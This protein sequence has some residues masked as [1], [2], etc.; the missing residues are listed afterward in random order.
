MMNKCCTRLLFC[1]FY[2]PATVFAVH[3]WS[4]HSYPDEDGFQR[5]MLPMFLRIA[6][7][8]FGE[9]SLAVSRCPDTGL[10]VKVWAVE[11]ETIISPYTGRAY[12]QGPTGYF[13]PRAR[14]EKGEIIAFGGD[15][16]KKD[17]PP[18]AAALL[19]DPENIEARAFLSIP[20]NLRQQYHFACSNWARAWP[21]LSGIMGRRW[22][23]QFFYRVG[24]YAE[25]RRPSDGG[26]EHL[27]LAK[28]H[29]LVGEPGHLLGGN[30]KDGGTENHKTMWRTSALLYSQLFPDTAKISGYTVHEAEILVKKMI[31]DYLKRL[32]ETG[33]GEYDS[34]V[35]YPYT[36]KS[37]LNLYDFSPDPETR[38]LAQCALDYYFATYGLKV[39]DGAIAGAQKRGYLTSDAASMME[40]MQWGFFND[41]SRDM[42][43]VITTL[44]QA[45]TNYRPNRVIYDITR[46]NIALP[47]EA[48]MGRPFYHMD[49]AHAF[50]E[51]FY[52]SMS[53]AMGNIQMSI[54][55]NPNQQMVWSLVCRGDTGPLCFSGGHPMRGSTSGHSPYTQT[56][57][58][59]GTLLLLTAPTKILND[60]DTLIAPGYAKTERPNLWHLPD[61]EQG[62]GFEVRH[63]QKYARAPLKPM[64]YPAQETPAEYEKFW[65]NNRGAA[66]SWFYYP[67][68]L[69]PVEKNGVW[70]IEAGE[71][72]IGVVPLGEKSTRIAPDPETVRRL[73]RGVGTFFKHYHL[74]VFPGK[75]SGYIVETGEK[76]HYGSPAAFVRALHSETQLDRKKLHTKLHLAYTTLAGDRLEMTYRP[77]RL[78]CD[79][80]IN[81]KHQDWETYT[82]GA[83]YEGPYVRVGNGKMEV[84]NG[85]DGYSVEFIDGRP[86]WTEMRI[87]AKCKKFDF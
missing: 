21:L 9:R 62:R 81:G 70:V 5:R 16:L 3:P 83:V 51:T 60:V 2:I 29:N 76:A 57:Q 39:I 56:L 41:T 79:A 1:L 31:R 6:S 48:R 13:G 61:S 32:L 78:R 40:I 33:N 54:V 82:G 14:N 24:T 49:H 59:K 25:S 52:C 75:I 8:G 10:P 74:L 46:K 65:E 42:G 55:D 72:F 85:K 19:L 50:A 27:P 12:V 80:K 64:I 86:V 53:Y 77:D 71:T 15:P 7:P 68:E 26:R 45:T 69:E 18:A 37:F 58:S 23:Q 38:E 20:G 44:H 47:F 35:Y 43:N 66:C 4:P 36:I 28:A 84:T 73:S 63:R 87:N 30:P 11:G 17:L 67:A 34:Q 22:E